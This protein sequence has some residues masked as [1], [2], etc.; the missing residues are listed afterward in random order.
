MYL[1]SSKIEFNDVCRSIRTQFELNWFFSNP[2]LS[3]ITTFCKAT[4][5]FHSQNPSYVRTY[6]LSFSLAITNKILISTFIVCCTLSWSKS[7]HT[8]IVRS[9][10]L[11]CCPEWMSKIFTILTFCL[12]IFCADARLLPWFNA[13]NTSCFLISLIYVPLINTAS[14]MVSLLLWHIVQIS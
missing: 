13:C 5:L 8:F 1:C 11:V 14:S 7:L 12:T 3:I 10:Y 4:L 9:S 6:Y 2:C